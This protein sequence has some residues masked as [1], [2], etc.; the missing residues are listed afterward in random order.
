MKK[1]PSFPEKSRGLFFTIGLVIAL[2]LSY[3]AFTM[4]FE[5]KQYA[6][7]GQ[8]EL[9]E[10]TFTI[11]NTY[12]KEPE[13]PKVNKKMVEDT[14]KTIT[15]LIDQF[16]TIDNIIDS[17]TEFTYD[18]GSDDPVD[19]SDLKDLDGDEEPTPISLLDR[20]PLFEGCDNTATEEE[21]RN[22]LEAHIFSKISKDVK[23]KNSENPFMDTETIWVTFVIDKNGEVSK[24][25][26]PR[27][28]NAYY[29][30]QIEKSIRSFPT[31]TP[32][33]VKSREV[34]CSFSMPIKITYR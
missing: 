3:S 7:A 31:F 2:G 14:K 22:C 4:K 13:R 23:I 34:A 24:V 30:S 6:I 12:T 16:V 25:E 18:D 15:T 33:I 21:K 28:G 19:L 1:S 17:K 9:I 11:P 29:T 8:G 26:F 32:G 5:K 20:L 27:G 10:D